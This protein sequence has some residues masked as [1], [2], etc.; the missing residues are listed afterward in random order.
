MQLEIKQPTLPEVIE[1]NFDDLKQEL[2]R[3]MDHYRGIVYTDDQIKDAKKD[4]AALRKFTTALSDERIRVKKEWMKPVESF[5]NKIKELTAIVN[6]P[7]VLISA[8]VQEYE[9]QK[10]EEKRQQILDYWAEKDAPAWLQ[11][12]DAKWLNA[13]ASLKSVKAEI[14]ARIEK[15]KEDLA[16][17]RAL[18]SY[19]FEAEQVYLSSLDLAKAVSEAHRLSEMAER[20]AAHEAEMARLKEVASARMA[21]EVAEMERV[22]E[23]IQTQPTAPKKY[24]ISFRA[25]MTVEQARELRDFFMSRG[26][27]YEKI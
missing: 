3:K 25:T 10:R 5:E 26:I 27:E 8:Q 9:E 11:Y 15:V 7:I 4:L 22:A 2:Q 12:I 18:P 13:S 1:F 20:K 23:S 19:A 14:D 24:T 17:I 6:E 21:A 16:V